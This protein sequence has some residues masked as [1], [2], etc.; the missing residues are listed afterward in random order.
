M[1]LQKKKAFVGLKILK[2]RPGYLFKLFKMQ[3][4]CFIT[5]ERG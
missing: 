2:P 1:P 4:N 5:K 3:L